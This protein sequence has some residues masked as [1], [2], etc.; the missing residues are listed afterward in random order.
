MPSDTNPGASVLGTQEGIRVRGH[1][2]ADGGRGQ[3][4]WGTC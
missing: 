3:G 4:G 2:H 1:Q